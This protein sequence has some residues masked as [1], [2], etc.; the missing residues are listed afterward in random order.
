MA[1]MGKITKKTIEAFEGK[2][3][4][5]EIVVVKPIVFEFLRSSDR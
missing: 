4:E 3:Q 5:K 2:R 1:E